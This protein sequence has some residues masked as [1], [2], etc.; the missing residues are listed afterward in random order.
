ML[1]TSVRVISHRVVSTS[2]RRAASS[3]TQKA[4]KQSSVNYKPLLVATGLA[5]AA[6]TLVQ[7]R[8]VRILL[9]C[10]LCALRIWNKLEHQN[11]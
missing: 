10:G 2:G 4:T 1:A 11:Y 6:A 3:V 5:L 7:D 9:F 8:E